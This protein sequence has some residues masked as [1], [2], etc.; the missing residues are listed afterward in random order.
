M[1]RRKFITLIGGGVI[2][3]PLAVHAQQSGKLPTIGFMG[4]G[5]P[6]GWSQW[7]AA[8][9]QRLHQLGWSEGRNVAIEYRWAEGSSE[10][11]ADNAAEFVRL[12]VDVIVTVGGNIAKQATSD[13]PIVF[14]LAGDPIGQGLVASLARPGGNITGMSLQ[15]VDLAGKRLEILR[16]FVPSLRKLAVFAFVG[17]TRSELELNEVQAAAKTLGIEIVMLEIRRAD[18]LAP[19]FDTLR[20]RAEALYV[21]SNPLANTNRVLINDLALSA[22]MPTV[23]GFR[24]YVDTG[25]LI[26]YGPSTP[27]LFRRTAE[28]VDKIL[29]GAKPGDLPVE[30]PTKFDLI[31]NLRTAK[32]LGLTVPLP[33]LSR[34]DEVI[35]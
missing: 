5:T 33:L 20:D 17:N 18:D 31:I 1:K 26:S 29:R 24:Q 27:D 13:I 9:L 4:A 32:A 21:P 7:T 6:S 16:E 28:Y 14:A 22:R 12:K 23:H 11:D 25:G 15:A 35:E 2:A 19:A 3:W 30:Q 8:F 10:R 34:A